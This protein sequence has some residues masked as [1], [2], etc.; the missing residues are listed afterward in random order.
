MEPLLTFECLVSLHSAGLLTDAIAQNLLVPLCFDALAQDSLSEAVTA[1]EPGVVHKL[2]LLRC[3]IFPFHPLRPCVLANWLQKIKPRGKERQRL[4]KGK[5]P[6]R[7]PAIPSQDG[8]CRNNAQG[9]GGAGAQFWLL[10]TV[11]SA[12][13]HFCFVKLS[14]LGLIRQFLQRGDPQ[15]CTVKLVSLDFMINWA[16]WYLGLVLRW[17]NRSGHS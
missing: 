13:P 1:M 16:L 15:I 7:F 10:H 14:Q 6:G 17:G 2:Y 12:I 11:S 5:C 8:T 9:F 4:Y 3:F